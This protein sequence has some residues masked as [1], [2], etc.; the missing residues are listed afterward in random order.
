[1]TQCRDEKNKRNWVGEG[2]WR[3]TP[4]EKGRALNLYQE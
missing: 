2:K 4:R 3:E 1:V